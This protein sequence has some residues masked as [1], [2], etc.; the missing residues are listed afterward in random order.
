MQSIK[1]TL[2]TLQALSAKY[3]FEITLPF[4]LSKNKMELA[5]HW[6]DIRL[7]ATKTIDKISFVFVKELKEE[8]INALLRLKSD[9]QTTTVCVSAYNNGQDDYDD[10]SE[11]FIETIGESSESWLQIEKYGSKGSPIQMFDIHIKNGT[12]RL[13]R[14][15]DEP[16]Q[17]YFQTNFDITQKVNQLFSTNFEY[18]SDE[19]VDDQ[20]EK[21]LSDL[22]NI[23]RLY[24]ETTDFINNKQRVKESNL[25]F[26]Y[27]KGTP[28][29]KFFAGM[30]FNTTYVCA[31]FNALNSMRYPTLS[32][33]IPLYHNIINE[34]FDTKTSFEREYTP[35]EYTH[36]L[37]T[38]NKI[39]EIDQT[40][41]A[42][43]FHT[44]KMQFKEI[45]QLFVDVTDPCVIT[46]I[47]YDL[48]DYYFLSNE[49]L[50]ALMNV[51]LEDDDIAYNKKHNKK[52]IQMMQ[53]FID[54]ITNS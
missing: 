24:A 4:T 10:F 18:I 15:I 42:Q 44:E 19:A 48:G 51:E 41:M 32:D 1:N 49:T 17:Y 6:L 13:I 30:V 27:R 12:M 53:S 20:K 28:H 9:S 35:Y 33:T 43:I 47:I 36:N 25:T 39:K 23:H 38:M 37:R 54:N 46:E 16:A 11:L 22:R 14:Y 29:T 8:L 3:S 34:G 52:L 5:L 26:N 31:D 21:F 50:I 2:E 45:K 40:A 7:D